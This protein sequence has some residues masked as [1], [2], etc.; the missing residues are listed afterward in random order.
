MVKQK[1]VAQVVAPVAVAQVAVPVAPTQVVAPKVSSATRAPLAVAK[2]ANFA[3]ARVAPDAAPTAAV[4]VK[5][6]KG[7]NASKVRVYGYDN[8]SSG[9]G[10]P[11][12]AILSVVPGAP[13]PSGV[14]PGQWAL[15]QKLAGKTVAVAYDNLVA[16]RS[17]RRAYRAG[18]IRFA[19]A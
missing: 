19:K 1:S 7:T 2:A 14:T 15:L 18:A 11:K 9:G 3:H 8:G 10:V 17:V 5:T 12:D 13:A 6:T 16:S 4:V